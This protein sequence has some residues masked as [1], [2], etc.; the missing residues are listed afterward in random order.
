MTRSLVALLLATAVTVVGCGSDGP[1]EGGQAQGD[2]MLASSF[3][4][5][6]V[7]RAAEV[8]LPPDV[9]IGPIPMDVRWL[10]GNRI[11]VPVER[12]GRD[13]V[14]VVTVLPDE[15][16]C[17]AE[18]AVLDPDEQ[19]DVGDEVC[20]VWVAEGRLPVVVPDPDAPVVVDPSDAA[21]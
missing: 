18:S 14:L 3:P 13:A 21:R 20:E 12:D 15:Q 16:A 17:S 7:L 6:S 10:P 4:L 5:T 2:T 11:E 1:E 19:A 9:S 8:A